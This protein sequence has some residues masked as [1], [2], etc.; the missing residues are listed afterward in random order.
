MNFTN[1]GVAMNVTVLFFCLA[2]VFLAIFLSR[3]TGLNTGLYAIVFAYIIGS[4]FLDIPVSRLVGHFSVKILFLLLSVSLFYGYASE[5]GMLEALANR[6]IYRFRHHTALLPFLLYL[7]CFG[8][9]GFGAAAPVVISLM[10]PVCYAIA[11]QTGIAPIVMS[12]LIVWGAGAGG[13][14]PWSSAGAILCGLISES[15]FARYGVRLSLTVCLNFFLGGLFCLTVLYL[16]TGGVR[17]RK[18]EME[19]PRAL[20]RKQSLTLWIMLG[21]LALLVLPGM[22]QV[23]CPN[24]AAAYL[25]AHLDLQ[26]LC[27]VGA[28][29]CGLLKLGDSRKILVHHVPWSVI[30]TVCGISM[31]LGLASDAGAM[32]LVTDILGSGVSQRLISLG[33]ILVGGFLSFFTGGVTVVIPMLVPVALSVYGT[34]GGSLPLLVSSAALGGLVTA[35]SPFSTG[36]SL[37][38][39]AMPE[40]GLR[41]KLINQ[42]ILAAFFGWSVF[43]LLA[44]TGLFGIWG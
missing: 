19:P 37:A 14:V 15:E 16:L 7:V 23:L 25:A 2:A 4:F 12:A 11:A 3:K 32:D 33:L 6:V 21:E 30:L 44:L 35:V 10:A 13:C 36:G 9:S 26:M 1:V 8:I 42:Q 24:P 22:I 39:S 5:N 17:T 29:I 34:Q 18:L 27:I 41:S 31:L 20:T 28:I 38:A 40:E 43:A